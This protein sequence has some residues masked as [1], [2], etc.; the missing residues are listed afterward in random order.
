MK[1]KESLLAHKY[2]SVINSVMLRLPS[3]KLTAPFRAV[4]P[5]EA[6]LMSG[7]VSTDNREVLPGNPFQPSGFYLVQFMQFSMKA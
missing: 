4:I 5:R 2:C 6:L 1:D 7:K 3:E